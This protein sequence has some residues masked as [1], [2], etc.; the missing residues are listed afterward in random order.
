MRHRGI[1][2]SRAQADSSCDQGRLWLGKAVPEPSS[3]R[4]NLWRQQRAS[5]DHDRYK[6]FATLIQKCNASV[7]VAR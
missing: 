6:P 7:R 4:R 3:S 5:T 2:L 1:A